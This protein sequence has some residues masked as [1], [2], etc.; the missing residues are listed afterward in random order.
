MNVYGEVFTNVAKSNTTPL[1]HLIL[2]ECNIS[3]KGLLGLLSI[4]KSLETLYLGMWILAAVRN[5]TLPVMS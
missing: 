4:P 3:H 5:L 2:E 1:R